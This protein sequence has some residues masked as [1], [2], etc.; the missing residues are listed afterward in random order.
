MM[1]KTERM[2]QVPAIRW[3]ILRTCN[4][5]GHLGATE[6]MLSRVID[7]EWLGISRDDMRKEL[8]YLSQRDLIEI[9]KS[10]IDPWRMTLTDHGRDLV[11]YQI[12]CRPGIARPPLCPD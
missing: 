5:G 3:S 6:T 1:N 2:R 8:H 9:E 7:A 12:D 11:D 10:E 4:V